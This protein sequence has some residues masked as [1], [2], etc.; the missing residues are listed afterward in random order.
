MSPAARVVLIT[1]TGT[2]VGKTVTTAV[3]VATARRNGLRVAAVKPTQTGLHPDEPGD[4]AA[5]ERL[6]GPTET[7]ELIRLPDPL[8]PDTAARIAGI[9][10]PTVEEHAA[11]VGSL[12]RRGDLD[13][14]LVEGAGGL[15]VRLDA[16]GADLSDLATS[17]IGQELDVRLVVVATAGLGTLN[18][19]ALTAEALRRRGLDC[20]G[21]VIG[22]WPQ[23]P[24][25]PDLAMRCNLEDLP[26]VTRSALLGVLP[27]GAGTWTA[28]RF[29]A[30]AP[31][32]LD[33]EPLDW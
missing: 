29:Q 26:A 31:G 6:A 7:H 18:H 32:W 12:A 14:V 16:A 5:V 22:S 4:L 17:L 20:A 27:A 2:D 3:L 21:F 15:L 30:E 24:T 33:V 25:E 19:S 10:I 13:V 1:G 11:Y 23:P 8:A 28:S 9:A